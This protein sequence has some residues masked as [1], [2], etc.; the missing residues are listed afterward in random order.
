MQN[1]TNLFPI[2]EDEESLDYLAMHNI[3]IQNVLRQ[4]LEK[5]AKLGEYSE[6]LEQIYLSSSEARRL[7]LAHALYRD[8]CLARK[9][10]TAQTV[11]EIEEARMLDDSFADGV[12]VEIVDTA[13]TVQEIEEARMLDDFFANGVPVEI[14]DTAQTVQEIEEARMLDDFFANEV[15]VEIVDTALLPEN[16]FFPFDSGVQGLE[17]GI[18]SGVA[19]MPFIVES[20]IAVLSL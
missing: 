7:E 1:T 8:E 11:Q 3:K 9:Y 6:E 14:V 5:R 18:Q 19:E 20:V 16:A 2:A 15:P 17:H 12:P 13:Q 4:I 10:E